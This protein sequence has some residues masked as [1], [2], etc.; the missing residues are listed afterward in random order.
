ML[1]CVS[2]S[3]SRRGSDIT[4]RGVTATAMAVAVYCPAVASSRWGTTTKAT[5]KEAMDEATVTEKSP[6][7]MFKYSAPKR[8]GKFDVDQP[9]L[10]KFP[11]LFQFA[12]T[13]I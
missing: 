13:K 2:S 7:M 3:G 11:L 6:A 4:A 12:E 5:A 10:K 1:Y 8:G 9:M